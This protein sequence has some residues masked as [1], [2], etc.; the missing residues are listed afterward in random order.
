MV[1]KRQAGI[2]ISGEAVRDRT[3]LVRL[4]SNESTW[5]EFSRG[6]ESLARQAFNLD[7]NIEKLKNILV[8]NKSAGN[9]AMV[10]NEADNRIV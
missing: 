6:A 3:E 5:I 1:G 9:G 4:F 8:G 10:V 7:V 2:R